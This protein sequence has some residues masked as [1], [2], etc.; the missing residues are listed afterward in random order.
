LPSYETALEMQRTLVA[1]T[2]DNL[3]RLK[4]LGDT[5]NAWGNC[6]F[7]QQKTK[8]AL[9]AYQEA[10]EIRSRL[11]QKAPNVREYQR[12]LA[13]AYMNVG[14]VEKQRDLAAARQ[15]FA[16]AQA[17]RERLR[18]GGVDDKKLQRDL[19]I[20][21]YNQAR[22]AMAEKSMPTAASLMEKAVAIFA[23]LARRDP[24]DINI[25][26][27]LAL[28]Y[29]LQADLNCLQAHCA[30]A[31][32]RFAEAS[33]M[34][35]SLAEANPS[36]VEYQMAAAEI[37]I[38]RAK[39]EDQ[40]ARTD[41]ATGHFQQALL[42]LTPLIDEFA[43][44]ARFRHNL[45][46]AAEQVA[47]RQTD[48]ARAAAAIAQLDELRHQLKMNASAASDPAAKGRRSRQSLRRRKNR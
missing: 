37:D 14:L 39:A 42:R 40:L 22:L 15:E 28:C 43:G 1:A 5:L 47:E 19:A 12:T 23:E 46:V 35:T 45:I 48:H 7:Q 9:A 26:Y 25:A 3:D 21:Y 24:A 38:N 34:M 10:L 2:P 27:Q 4:A 44:D 17:I 30:A 36:V 29:R 6:L 16:A 18:D 13:N 20:G 31:L 33:R 41:L 11:V 32:P 8:Q